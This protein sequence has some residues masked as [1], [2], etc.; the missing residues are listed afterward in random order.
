MPA[1]LNV[2]YLDSPTGPMAS[3]CAEIIV[4][5][6][7]EF[8]DFEAKYVDDSVELSVPAKLDPALHE[9]IRALAIE[10]FLAMAGEGLGSGRHVCLWHRCSDQR[11]KH[12]ARI[13]PDFD[14][15]ADVGGNRFGLPSIS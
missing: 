12:H 6:G 8:Y 11:D 14:V 9:K 15:S 1:K 2:A 10:A 5:D 4:R 3:V 7:H 13:Y